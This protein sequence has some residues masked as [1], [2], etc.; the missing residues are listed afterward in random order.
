V[1]DDAANRSVD[2]KVTSTGEYLGDGHKEDGGKH[3]DDKIDK[4][5]PENP[6]E[7]GGHWTVLEGIAELVH[8][9]AEETVLGMAAAF[10]APIKMMAEVIHAWEYATA[11]QVAYAY[12]DALKMGAGTAANQILNRQARVNYETVWGWVSGNA[13]PMGNLPPY[14][15]ASHGQWFPQY[16]KGCQN[17]VAPYNPAM[18]KTEERVRQRLAQKGLSG[19]KLKSA[20]DVVIHDVRKQVALAIDGAIKKKATELRFS[21]T[22]PK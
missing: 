18:E 21:V 14:Y 7:P 19:P 6:H 9:I 8:V 1:G 11:A 13:P 3:V 5:K 4:D 17:G 22:H 10:V 15:P 2:V 16:E 20:F 12:L